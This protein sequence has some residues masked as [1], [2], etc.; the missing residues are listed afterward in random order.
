MKEYYVLQAVRLPKNHPY[1]HGKDHAVISQ[2]GRL[3]LRGQ[4]RYFRT[5]EEAEAFAAGFVKRNGAQFEFEVQETTGP[6]ALHSGR[7]LAE[8]SFAEKNYYIKVVFIPEN[9][10]VNRENLRPI[11]LKGALVIGKGNLLAKMGRQLWF[12]THN[13]GLSHLEKLKLSP[14]Y[15]GC[16][17]ELVAA[18]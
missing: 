6:I 3:C 18:D 13:D 15:Q 11:Y 17:F 4:P 1:V 12:Q 7:Q 10:F 9:R 14:A 2:K 5:V 8:N 16:A